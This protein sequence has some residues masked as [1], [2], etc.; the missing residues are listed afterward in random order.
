MRKAL[1]AAAAVA[2]LASASAMAQNTIAEHS[3]RQDEH[4]DDPRGRHGSEPASR[5]SVDCASNR[6]PCRMKAPASSRC[7]TRT[8]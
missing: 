5:R 4:P 6:E 2:A 7:R 1:F 8:C 3:Q